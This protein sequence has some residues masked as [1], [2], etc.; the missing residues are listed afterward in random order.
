MT[1]EN[2]SGEREK[3]TQQKVITRKLYPTQKATVQF[4]KR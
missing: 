3:F 2:V 4:L 1:L